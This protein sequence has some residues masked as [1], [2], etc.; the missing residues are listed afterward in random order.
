[1]PGGGRYLYGFNEANQLTS[2]TTPSGAETTMEYDADGNLI[3]LTDPRGGETTSTYDSM[4]RIESET[5]PLEHTSEW[6]YDKAGKLTKAVD[7]RGKVSQFGY[8]GLGRLVNASFGVSGL[9]AESTIE[10]AYDEGDRLV[11]VSD[12]S[13]GEYTLSHD[14]LDRLTGVEGPGGSVGYEYDAAGRR[15]A[16]SLPG[17]RTVSY[18]YDN[19]DRLTEVASEGDSA[20]LAYD[21]ANRLERL[22]LP[23]GIEQLYGYDKAGQ[24]TS[25]T[26]P[27]GAGTLGEIDYAYD[28]DGQTEAIW[29]S[30]ARL[31]LPEALKSAKYNAA[32]EMTERE[33]KALSYDAD[34]NLTSDGSNEYS[35]NAR[36]QLTEISGTASASFGYDPFGR[37]ISKTLGG[38]TTTLLYDG[39][40]VA[41]ESVGSSVTAKLLTG[42]AADQLFSRTT[43]EG[44]DSYL[45][46]KLGSTIGL[47]NGSA[48]V[49]TTYT[50]DPFGGSTVTG[51]PSTN[52]YQFT[53]REND[54]TGLQYNRAR[55]YSPASGR[56]VSQDPMGFAGA[57]AN[58]YWYGYAD[59]LDFVD[60]SGECFLICVPDPI[61]AAE[62]AIHKVG[63]WVSGAPSVISK[64]DHGF[65]DLVA[66][67]PYALYYGSYEAARGINSLG[68]HLGAPGRVIAHTING[69]LVVTQ[70]AGLAA[71]AGIDYVKG[72]TVAEESV[73]DEGPGSEV[74]INPLHEFIPGL[75]DHVIHDAPG[76]SESGHI[77]I[78]W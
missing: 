64:I 34:G 55:Y 39:P 38:T 47:A 54:G 57:G 18:A 19:A 35:W 74:H 52:P 6:S 12:T 24:P 72:H 73:G 48:E 21:K 44:T 20:S 45:S 70:G 11:G 8:D 23:D 65:L 22:T 26:Y 71:D 36:G 29:G 59:P 41:Q 58:L 30:Y 49:E 56:F 51:E 37:R 53:G 61:S 33:G 32:N 10:Y 42:L 69:P 27:H 43:G 15:T 1:M 60:P 13:S 50:Y 25:I 68:S 78:E 31:A 63:E 67:P 5:G 9:T 4:D 77:D 14:N 66:V 62:D 46:D 3:K 28:A 2:E 7:R 75:P 16:M 17:S 76:I 40:N